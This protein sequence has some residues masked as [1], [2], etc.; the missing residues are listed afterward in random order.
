MVTNWSI[1][2]VRAQVDQTKQRKLNIECWNPR[3]MHHYVHS[4]AVTQRTTFFSCNTM[5]I[6]H[7][8]YQWSCT[9]APWRRHYTPILRCL[10]DV[11]SWNIRLYVLINWKFFQEIL[12]HV[13]AKNIFQSFLTSLKFFSVFSENSPRIF[14]KLTNEN[15]CDFC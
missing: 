1:M 15:F 8:Y 5:F 4:D 12:L 6:L 7:F 10:G 2:A 13:S 9:I 3:Q 11:T 14:R